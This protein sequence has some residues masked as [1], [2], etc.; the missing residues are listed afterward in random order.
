MSHI[1][2]VATQWHLV[3]GRLKILRI[4]AES[5]SHG[6]TVVFPQLT[7]VTCHGGPIM[8]PG[9]HLIMGKEVVPIIDTSW[10]MMLTVSNSLFLTSFTIF[11]CHTFY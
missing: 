3:C 4:A 2:H 6:H 8:Y 11:W 7:I 1:G 9:A 10:P 5:E